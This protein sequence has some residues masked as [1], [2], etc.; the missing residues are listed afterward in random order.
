LGYA[1]HLHPVGFLHLEARVG[2]A[3]LQLAVV[4]QQQQALAVGIQPPGHIHAG[5]GTSPAAVGAELGEH[6][7][8]LVQQQQPGHGRSWLR[9]AARRR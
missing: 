5:Q 9:G 1:L 2:N 8:G 3:G 7:E 6:V 4:G